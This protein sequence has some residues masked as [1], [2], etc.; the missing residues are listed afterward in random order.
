MSPLP[1]DPA[2][3]NNLVSQDII[4]IKT[5]LVKVK[6]LLEREASGGEELSKDNHDSHD[7][8]SEERKL[9]EEQLMLMKDELKLKDD[10]IEELEKIVNAKKE[11][12]S[13]QVRV[14]MMKIFCFNQHIFRLGELNP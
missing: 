7:D 1:L 2:S 4:E 9:L 5:L 12:V 13:T 11:N 10:K 3:S 8:T 14:C 6:G